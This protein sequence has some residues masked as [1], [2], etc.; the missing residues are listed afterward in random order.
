MSKGKF[1]GQM[2]VVSNVELFL[3]NTKIVPDFYKIAMRVS[4]NY[5][6]TYAVRTGFLS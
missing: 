3:I 1:K 2:G 4:I 5:A 6:T